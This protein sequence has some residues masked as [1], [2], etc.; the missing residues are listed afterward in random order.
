MQR[1]AREGFILVAVLGVLALLAGLVGAVSVLVRSAVDSARIVSDDLSLEGLV[2]AGIEIAG[3]QL[4]GLKLPF[5][6]INAQQVRFDAGLVTLFVTDESGKIDLNG[7]SPSVLAGAYR[8]VG[9]ST[10]PA[11]AFAARITDWRDE[12]DERTNGGAEAPEYEA[13]GLDYRPQNDAFRSVDELQWLL[14]L[15]PAQAA[16]LAPL[17]TVHNPDGKVNVL[18]ASREVLLALPGLNPP[19]V[20]RILEIREKRTD[21]GAPDLMPLLPAQKD[22]VKLEP[23]PSYRVRIEARNRNARVKSVEVVLTPSRRRDA[24]YYVVEW[25]E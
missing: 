14:G 24:L 6:R 4:Y 2:Q 23:G 7:A 25:T 8:A 19:T 1:R 10:L 3:Y 18:S 20:D 15:A 22:F 11:A 17:M 16:V 12:D 5:D 21:A 13:A 9:L